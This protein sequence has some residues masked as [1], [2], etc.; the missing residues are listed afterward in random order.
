[1]SPSPS[2][3]SELSRG[4]PD[5]RLVLTISAVLFADTMFYA[6]IAPLLPELVREVHLSKLSAGVLTASYPLG[7]L[8]GSLPAAVSTTRLGPKAT[9]LAGLGMLAGSTIAF[10]FLGSAAALDAARL[11]EGV[12]GA[13]S[14]TGGIAML[15]DAAAPDQRGALIGRALAAAVAGA[16]VG[17]AIGTLA[18]AAGRPLAFSAVVVIVALL[19]AAVRRLP[20]SPAGSQPDARSAIRAFHDRDVLLAM[21]LIVLPAVVAGA[22]DVL[23]PLRLH[24]LGMSAVGVGAAFLLCAGAEAA[25]SPLVGRFSDR[26]GRLPPIR[27]GLVV[28]TALL[29]CFTLPHS[30]WLLAGLVVLI[31]AAFG[32]LWTPAMALLSDACERRALGMGLVGALTNLAWAGGQIV[33]SAGGGGIARAAGDGLAIAITAALCVA[34]LVLLFRIP[35]PVVGIGERG[36]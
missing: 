7:T 17:P 6:A 3:V 4:A 32:A 8:L 22:F 34:T 30:P 29:L 35:A 36:S 1:V 13:F 14:W 11:V 20:D 21:W 9:V 5:R 31:G 16:L 19:I 10:A 27:A 33:G 18:A 24:R 26:R 2:A 25:V 12:G 23:A 28:V 15:I